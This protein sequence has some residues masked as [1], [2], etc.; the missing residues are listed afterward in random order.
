[1]EQGFE[2][3]LDVV[4]KKA[5]IQLQKSKGKPRSDTCAVQQ[6]LACHRG[7]TTSNSK[8]RK[9]EAKPDYSPERQAVKPSAYSAEYPYRWKWLVFMSDVFE[10]DSNYSI[11]VPDP[12][13]TIVFMSES[14][15]GHG[16]DCADVRGT[17]HELRHFRTQGC[18]WFNGC[19]M[20]TH[21]EAE[22]RDVLK[23][24]WTPLYRQCFT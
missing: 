14:H 17:R 2:H 13:V 12:K 5:L 3:L 4:Q 9:R 18:K 6:L 24:K 7:K 19:Y 1:M 11:F 10:Q 23:G 15:V 16:P 8:Q 20:A 22:N 21:P